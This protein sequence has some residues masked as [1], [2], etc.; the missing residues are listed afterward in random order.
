MSIIFMFGAVWPRRRAAEHY[1][2]RYKMNVRIWKWTGLVVL[3]AT[4]VCAITYAGKHE[5]KEVT[6]PAAVKDAIQAAYPQATV[7][8]A[9]TE[10][11]FKVYEVI[12][13][14]NAKES[15]I[16]VTPEGTIIEMEAKIDKGNIPDA[17]AKALSKAAEGA[18]IKAVEQQTAYFVIKAVKLD[19]PE[20]AYT[21][22]LVKDGKQSEIKIAV[23]G[24]VL[25]KSEWKK[26]E[27]K[28]EKKCEGKEEKDEQEVTID[29]VPPAVKA[30]ILKEAGSGT[31]KEI[32]QN[33]KDGKTIYGADIIIDGNKFEIKVSSD[34]NLLKKQ[35]E[36]KDDENDGED[37]DD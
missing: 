28:D 30:T 14:Q 22:D 10:K 31:I 13:T 16:T 4:M 29:Q 9:N 8:I 21:A 26:P 36:D 17:V 3:V 23:N 19:S 7:G 34:G 24:N 37:K 35:V 2:R 15:E 27:G 20:T 1:F 12:V 33:I 32:E 25:E 6:L 18:E 11:E 5:S